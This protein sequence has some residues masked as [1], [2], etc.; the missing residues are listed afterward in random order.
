MSNLLVQS[1]LV[2]YNYVLYWFVWFSYYE[3][4]LISGM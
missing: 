1:P 2:G 4:L 3:K